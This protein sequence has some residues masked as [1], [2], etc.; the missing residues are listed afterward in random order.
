[1]SESGFYLFPTNTSDFHL[2]IATDADILR[3]DLQ[4]LFLNEHPQLKKW[5]ELKKTGYSRHFLRT[6][7][8]STHFKNKNLTAKIK[9]NKAEK[10]YFLKIV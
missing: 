3:E 4:T 9:K 2:R 7:I 8:D 10:P 5:F 1:M 6:K